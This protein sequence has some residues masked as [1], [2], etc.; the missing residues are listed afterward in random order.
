MISEIEVELNQN[1]VIPESLDIVRDL[2]DGWLLS[3]RLPVVDPRHAIHVAN[4]DEWNKVDGDFTCRLDYDLNEDS[5]VFDVGGYLGEWAVSIYARHKCNIFI[6]EPV[7]VYYNRIQNRLKGND[8]FQIFNYGLGAHTRKMNVTTIGDE[9]SFYLDSSEV[10][11]AQVY[12][13]AFIIDKLT[14]NGTID[15]L[16]L[17]I[18]GGEYEV[19]PRLIE[20]GHIKNIT[21]IQ[22][23]FHYWIENFDAQIAEIRNRLS[24]THV[25]TYSYEYVWENWELKTAE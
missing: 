19:L 14:T 12:D 16:K 24:E 2:I 18:E 25:C 20:S 10:Q 15:L 11:D 13:A 1:V 6:F 7:T 3:Q 23:Q 21:N 17:N 9:S 8:K 4:V 22:V 5:V